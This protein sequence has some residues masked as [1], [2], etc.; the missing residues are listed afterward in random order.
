VLA[1]E[2]VLLAGE[3]EHRLEELAADVV[4]EQALAVL[5]E[6]AL[7][8]GGILDVHVQEPLEEEV[9]LKPLAELALTA[10]GIEG[11]QQAGLEQVL[12]RDG[13]T[14]TFG[15]HLIEDRT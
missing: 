5:G 9:V 11:H 4:L 6:G 8:E 2:Q 14:T 10:D 13:R 7:I 15:V 1:G 3:V 12:G